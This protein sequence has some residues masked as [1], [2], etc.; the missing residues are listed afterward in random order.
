MAARKITEEE[1][2]VLGLETAKVV[3]WSRCRN[4]TNIDRFKQIYGVIPATC[5][6]IW[7]D[8]CDTNAMVTEY[9]EPIKLTK[10]DK[11]IDL[12]V[13]L[14]FLW[15][16]QNETNIG[17][18]FGIQSRNTVFKLC[19]NWTNKIQWLLTQKVGSKCRQW[20]AF[21]LIILR[22]Y[23]QLIQWFYCIVVGKALRS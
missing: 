6:L 19:S 12:L 2:L 20:F 21:F 23:H 15:E 18:F 22:S 9:D 11:P 8:L 17:Q 14:R 16:Y 3:G 7:N 13:G 1:F 4:A 10:K 5:T